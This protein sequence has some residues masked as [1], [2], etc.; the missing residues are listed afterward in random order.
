MIKEGVGTPDGALEMVKGQMALTLTKKIHP[1]TGDKMRR[2]WKSRGMEYKVFVTNCSKI[3]KEELKCQLGNFIRK[4][5][6]R[7]K[8]SSHQSSWNS[9]GGPGKSESPRCSVEMGPGTD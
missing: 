8:R 2:R 1:E 6:L 3:V 4:S 9:R 5:E 7:K